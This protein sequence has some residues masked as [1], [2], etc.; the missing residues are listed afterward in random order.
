MKK[1][2]IL[3]IGSLI[4]IGCAAKLSYMEMDKTGKITKQFTA[5]DYSV[6]TE[7]VTAVPSRWLT[8]NFVADF[9]KTLA[10]III[11]L[12]NRTSNVSPTPAPTP[13]PTPTPAP[14]PAPTPYP[15]PEP[16]PAPTPSPTP[17]SSVFNQQGNVITLNMD[18]LPGSM[19]LAGFKG[20]D[21][22]LYY[23]IANIYRRGPGPELPVKAGDVE[24]A[25]LNT[26]RDTIY[27]WFD[28]EVIKVKSTMLT[29]P[30]TTL[31]AITND[32]PDR[33]G[34]R[35]GP[36]IA[37]RLKEFGGRVQVGNVLPEP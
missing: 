23:A 34:C 1:I 7:I 9:W 17:V 3:V 6:K 2:L 27:K 25:S 20:R 32:A 29:Y 31:I 18:T 33:L 15:A 8:P 5:E 22:A 24:L 4:L 11:P 21:N 37:D 26:Q 30:A 19:R 16:T 13:T 36:A 10:D 14:A 28:A 12:I 35:L